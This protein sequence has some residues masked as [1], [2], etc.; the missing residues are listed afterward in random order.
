MTNDESEQLEMPTEQVQHIVKHHRPALYIGAG[1][2]LA[3]ILIFVGFEISMTPSA[4]ILQKA[5]ASE[6]VAYVANDRGLAKL[7]DVQQKQFLEEWQKHLTDDKAREELKTCL[8]GMGDE[9]RKGFTN[10]IARQYKKSFLE[11]ARHFAQLRTPQEKSEFCR[12]KLI[13]GR[14]QALQLKDI[15]VVLK[16]ASGQRMDDVQQWV[17]E[18]TSAEERAIGEPYVDALKRVREQVKKEERATAAKP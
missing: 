10:A 2:G 14:D 13:E 12:K 16:T 7:P 18:N 3:I 6:V 15:A 9:Q 17:L 8:K 4:P 5:S 11:D 1:L